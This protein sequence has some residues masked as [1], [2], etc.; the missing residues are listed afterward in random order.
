MAQNRRRRGGGGGNGAKPKPLAL[1]RPVPPLGDP[2][3]V[4]PAEDPTAVLKSLGDPP[5]QGQGTVAHFYMAEVI[6]RAAG[7]AQALAHT[8]G[9][10]VEGDDGGDEPDEDADDPDDIDEDD[11]VA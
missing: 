3:R 6:R 2:P 11:E 9:V 4:V 7:L 10:L 5:L 8:A 1:W